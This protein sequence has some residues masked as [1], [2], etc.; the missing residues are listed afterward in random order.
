MKKI[1]SVVAVAILSIAGIALAQDAR[2]DLY[3]F[4]PQQ[5]TRGIY[6][7]P[8]AAPNVS[9]STI[10]RISRIL[11]GTSASTDFAATATACQDTASFTVSGARTGDACIAIAPTAMSAIANANLTC[12]VSAADT[13]IVRFCSSGT[14]GDPAASTY[15]VLVISNQ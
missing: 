14:P 2:I 1:L 4:N 15:S 8:E 11:G 5:F 12:R 7:G 10:N 6:I 9:A 13:V 3:R